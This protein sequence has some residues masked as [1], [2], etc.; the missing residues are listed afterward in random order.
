MNKSQSKACKH[1]ENSLVNQIQQDDQ[2]DHYVRY[3]RPHADPYQLFLIPPMNDIV[4][5]RQKL[6]PLSPSEKEWI[7][8]K[9]RAHKECNI[10]TTNVVTNNIGFVSINILLIS[11][12]SP[13]DVTPDSAC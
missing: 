1:I 6:K 8:E 12:S 2:L 13:P 9:K 7:E 10:E 5:E 11:S 3:D 4:L